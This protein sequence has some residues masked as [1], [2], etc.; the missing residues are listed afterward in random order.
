M[1]SLVNNFTQNQSNIL[2]AFLLDKSKY[3]FSFKSII[4]LLQLVFV[5]EVGPPKNSLLN[6]HFLCLVPAWIILIKIFE[7]EEA[8]AKVEQEEAV[9]IIKPVY[10]DEET[11]T[12]ELLAKIDEL[13]NN[14]NCHGILLQ[15]PVP[16]QIEERDCFDSITLEKDV[17]PR[18]VLG[19]L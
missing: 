10:P 13:N 3:F 4:K 5:K 6:K 7:V 1:L 12:E 18:A 2:F 19:V 17:V 16:E 11:T 9:T 8:A 14:P 15:H